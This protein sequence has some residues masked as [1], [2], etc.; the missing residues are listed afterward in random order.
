MLRVELRGFEFDTELCTEIVDNLPNELAKIEREVHELAGF[1]FDVGSSHQVSQ[2]LFE[3]M[4]LEIPHGTEFRR[5]RV[6][7]SKSVLEKLNHPV[8]E[9]IMAYRRL[10][11]CMPHLR[12]FRQSVPP[13]ES[14]VHTVFDEL[15]TNSGRI[16][17][18]HP[19]VQAVPKSVTVNG[20]AIRS[21]FIASPG[22][23]LV[24]G[25]YSQLELRVLCQLSEDDALYNY[26]NDKSMDPFERMALEFGKRTSITVDRGKAKQVCYAMIYG[27]G[28]ETLSTELSVSRSEAQDLI[29]AFYGQ[30]PGVRCWMDT[31][32]QECRMYCYVETYLGRRRVFDLKSKDGFERQAIN[33]IIQGTAAEIFRQAIISVDNGLRNLGG[34]VVMQ[35]HDEIIAE[36]PEACLEAG[37]SVL[38]SCMEQSF[39]EFKVHFPIKL[40]YGRNW[41]DLK[42]L[43]CTAI[44][45]SDNYAFDARFIHTNL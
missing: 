16:I 3:K 38:K 20:K 30:F 10:E 2:A 41:G 24:T 29:N 6:R 42:S 23:Y 45:R 22:M 11:D 27:M 26:L 1:T 17:S 14:R 18:K 4:R 33:H 31:K 34:G 39:P 36:V 43:K 40:S 32:V 28:A 7:V 15:A 37:S 12:G 35:I 5:G 19:N 8:A 44:S 25:D 9:L 13:G 21:M